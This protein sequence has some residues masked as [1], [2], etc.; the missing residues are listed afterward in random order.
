[1]I[2][3]AKLKLGF[4]TLFLAAVNSLW[5]QTNPT[6]QSLPYSQDF[7][8][9]AYASTTYLTGT[10]G[11]TVG[12]AAG[13]TFRTVAP[14]GDRVLI[15][16]SSAS[17]NSGGIHNYNGKIGLLPSG[18]VDPAF[19]WAVNTT[20]ATNIRLSYDIMTI[21]NPYDGASNTK[22][23]EATIQYRIGTS[24]SFTNL[25]GIEY[26]NNTT[27][28][29]GAGV[30][31]PQNLQ[32]KTILLPVACENQ[33]V[34]QLRLVMRDVSGV[35]SRV[36]MAIDNI[37][38][39]AESTF[40]ADVD[41]DTYGDAAS[42][43]SS[44]NAPL[45]YVSNNTDCNDGNSAVHPGASEICNGIDDDCAGGAD[46]GLTFLNYYTDGDSDGFGDMSASAVNSCSAVAGSVTNNTDCNDANNSIYPGA[47]D[48]CNGGI[49]DD[50]DGISDEDGIWVVY[51]YDNDGD[52]Y[53]DPDNAGS[54]CSGPPPSYVSDNTD[55]NDEDAA[56]NPGASE[57]CN[58]VDDNCDG[59]IDEGVTTTFYAD[60]DGDNYG[61]D[62]STIEACDLPEGYWYSGGD[63]DDNDY[64]TNPGSFDDVC[65]GIDRNCD[66]MVDLAPHVLLYADADGDGYGSDI[67]YNYFS[68][69]ALPTGYVENGGDCN[70]GNASTYPGA[71]EIC[72]GEDNDCNDAIDD[73]LTFET[74]YADNDADNYGDAFNT[75]STCNGM[76]SGYVTDASDCDD[77]QS[78]VYPGAE[79]ICDGL[80]NDC[81][82]DYDEGIATAS[83]TPSGIVQICKGVSTTLNANT[84]AGYTYQWFKNGHLITGATSDSYTTTKTGYYEV[85]VTTPG[86]CFAV[87]DVTTVSGLAAP[88]ANI[89]APNGLNLCAGTVKL[90]ASYDGTNMYQWYKDGMPVGGATSYLYIATA[91]GNYYCQVT[92]ANGCQ[93]NTATVTVINACRE[94]NEPIAYS[95]SP[96]PANGIFMV[97]G[98]TGNA[99][100]E[101]ILKIYSM[102][103]ELIAERNIEMHNGYFNE[104]FDGAGLS[105]GIYLIMIQH[106]Q[107]VYSDRIVISK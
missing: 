45:G 76:P 92:A 60:A 106:D 66:G 42:S 52:T 33:A 14:T 1:M 4:F 61:D 30:T 57:I 28:Q 20:G 75:T 102:A 11:W 37:S 67:D 44:C 27:L 78:T 25:T 31:T 49:D 87:S 84:G 48:I 79:E 93:K 46:D 38:V 7:S 18:S 96:N 26:Q 73:G 97:K 105:N 107:S 35:G 50:C 47:E 22:I 56:V 103:G 16:S 6:A 9:L 64:M 58:S 62:L 63:C 40:Y 98:E 8:G 54:T 70:D 77:T 74:W 95:I 34:V 83:I 59:N 68:V 24:G 104:E 12:T 101:V 71:V 43:V 90:K 100:G 85:Q 36:S 81:D 23:N 82:G 3:F 86:G 32:S 72:D 91:T 2:K 53:G 94:L 19:C 41:T 15:A 89:N 21:R 13:S 55:C 69:C 51:Y 88:N 17:N 10:Q 80:D 99:S 29:T 39:C 65:A 5:A